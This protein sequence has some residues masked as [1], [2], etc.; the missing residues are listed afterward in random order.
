MVIPGEVEK[1]KDVLNA[2]CFS[3]PFPGYGQQHASATRFVTKEIETTE[4]L[5]VWNMGRPRLRH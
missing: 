2:L 1:L 5:N 4:E 3:K